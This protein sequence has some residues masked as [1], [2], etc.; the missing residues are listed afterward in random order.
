MATGWRLWRWRLLAALGIPLLLLGLTELVLR[1]AGF[2]YPTG[3][4]LSTRHHGQRIWSQNNRFGWR[5]FS[6]QMARSPLP[7]AI[8]VQKPAHAVRIFVF[9]ESA[10][11]GDP[12]PRYGFGRLLQT[13]LTLR[14][15]GISFEV[16]NTAMTGINS[17]V[18][19]AI[20]RDCAPAAG[21]I[22]VVYMGNNEVVGPFGA[23]TVFGS[24]APP[25]PLVRA[26]IALRA[27][28]LG[29]L[30]DAAAR[31]LHP[32]PAE[33]S[34]WGGML[35]FLHQQVSAEDPRMNRVY[36]NFAA[37]LADI[38]DLGRHS[39]AGVIV[40]T[41][42]VNLKDCA[43]FGSNPSLS[44]ADSTPALARALEEQTAGQLAAAADDF[45]RALQSAPTDAA[46]HFR[47][48]QCLLALGNAAAAAEQFQAARDLD[49]LR[50]RCDSKLNAII[51][52]VASDRQQQRVRLADA[53]KACA[54]ASAA[55]LPGTELFYDHV[56]PTF[57]GN[58]VL[59]RIITEQAE[60]LLPPEV[61]LGSGAWPTATEC[62]LRLGRTEID[63]QTAVSDM[64]ARLADAPFTLQLNHQEQLKALAELPARERE[65][66][67]AAP[68]SE[69]LKVCERAAAAA[70]EDALLQQ[71]LASCKF[72]A[73]DLPGA[74]AAA[75]RAV[76]LLP[77]S[78]QAWSQLGLIYAQEQKF[79]SA[80]AA[81]QHACQLDPQ[82]V[83]TAQRVG[84]TLLR[85]GRPAEAIREYRRALAVKPR[86]GPVW[87]DLGEAL[88]AQNQKAEAEECY[89]KALTN[90][91]HVASELVTLARFCQ[92]RGW[93]EAACT[94]FLEAVQ[95][96]PLEPSLHL[97]AGQSLAALRR[98]AQAAEQFAKSVQLSPDFAQA[99]FLYGVELGRLGQDTNAEVQFRQ[100]L[101]LVPEAVE[102]RLNLGISLF[103]QNRT[104][105][106]LVE[107][108]KVLERQPQN[109]MAQKYRQKIL[110]QTKAP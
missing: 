110:A 33:Q 103:Y 74:E 4:L 16:I 70:P 87:L 36:N 106:A 65:Q 11:M 23:G 55:R 42:A 52:R 30:F 1:W 71:A 75:Q 17:H 92:S 67:L 94:N 84:Q 19:R 102:A 43:P 15:P 82:D 9:G 60:A 57:A 85:L 22:W 64:L 7:L 101:Q 66:K 14:H 20:A 26:G 54:D 109:A 24:Q 34:D 72:F 8:P 45:Q 108:E 100:A 86:F 2:G 35:M 63:V 69:A 58:Y 32:P 105:E 21:D 107:F 95:L 46:L 44:A 77:S 83:W 59:A 98:D 10:A 41:V 51:R 31:R 88:E 18:V 79:E 53:E 80:L 62:S 50:F 104:N 99:H 81:H 61:G 5:F 97:E 47:L 91:I 76:D 49:T 90:R 40:S 37:N 73:G 28:R 39:G 29:Q 25:L 13:M 93:S 6:P 27:T 12:Q 78:S 89:R 48:A 3:F 68:N 38:I 56:H 96:S